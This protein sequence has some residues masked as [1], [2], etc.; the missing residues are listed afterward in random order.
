MASGAR[1]YLAR[2]RRMSWPERMWRLVEAGRK[3]HDRRRPRPAHAAALAEAALENLPQLQGAFTIRYFDV[4]FPWSGEDIDWQGDGSAGVA[5][6][7]HW[8]QI[9]YRD[10]TRYRDPK[11]TWELNRQQFLRY[12]LADSTNDQTV[13][14]ALQRVVLQWIARNPY[15]FG[16]N[17]TSS[18]EAALRLISWESALG[19]LRLSP[20]EHPEFFAV[21]S[22]SVREHALHLHLYPSRFSSANNHRLGEL[23][24]ELAAAVLLPDDTSLRERARDAWASFLN[25]ILLQVSTDGVCRE[26]A[27]FY[28]AYTLLYFKKALG[29]AAKLGLVI[30]EWAEHRV[31]LMQQWLDAMTDEHGEWFEIGDR[32]DGDLAALM[33]W[34]AAPPPPIAS[35]AAAGFYVYPDGGYAAGCNGECHVCLRGGQLGYPS[36]AAHAHCDLLSVLMKYRWQDVLTDSGTYCYH[37]KPHWR[38]RF[39][40]TGAHNTLQ[41]NGWEQA[42]YGGPFLWMTSPEAPITR[43]GENAAM[44]VLTYPDGTLHQ[45]TM[46]LGCVQGGLLRVEDEVSAPEVQD[47]E[48]IWN[49]APGVEPDAATQDAAK[50]LAKATRFEL[51]LRVQDAGVLRMVIESDSPMAL[52]LY[53]WNAEEPMAVYSR[54]F[55]VMEPIWQ[56]RMATRGHGWR[57]T[58]TIFRAEDP[59]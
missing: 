6:L 32:D 46:E 20:A 1:W 58:T 35:A 51:P 21:L 41:I 43:T 2:L 36:I 9:D 56:I 12:W 54:R 17:W 3:R 16:I 4:E 11:Q 40:S 19:C 33:D 53:H 59:A 18:L 24:G 57:V 29:Y 27:T 28:H 8:T 48:L 26:Q 55:G 25:E 15:G 30:P 50:G 42:V 45:R 5:P 22:E 38:R 52:H 23:L 7:V 37:D 44:G 34:N 10:T 14:A 39:K 49:L 47:Y 31:G 13:T